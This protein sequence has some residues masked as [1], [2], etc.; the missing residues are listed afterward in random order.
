M[1][2]TGRQ[3]VE[4]DVA[5]VIEDLN[6]AAADEW[7]AAYQYWVAAKVISGMNASLVRQQLEK[8]VA[9]ELEHAGELAERVIELGGTP[10]TNPN[11]WEKTRNCAYF[12]PPKDPTNLHE[13]IQSVLK[14]E[15][16]AIEGYHKLAKKTLQK[17]PVT[18]NV[19]AH[20]LSEEVRHEEDFENL[21]A[22]LM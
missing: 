5:E 15:A 2:R 7:S 17:D 18:Y 1:G 8:S 13:V 6:R 4:L 16:C 14:A 10:P 21:S 11:E 12:E 3:V 22:G 20:I 19:V 9:Q